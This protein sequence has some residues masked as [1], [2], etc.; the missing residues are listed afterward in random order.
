LLTAWAATGTHSASIASHVFIGPSSPCIEKEFW[1]FPR[2][3][4]TRVRGVEQR[5]APGEA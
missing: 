2:S 3:G 4:R 5:F 1:H